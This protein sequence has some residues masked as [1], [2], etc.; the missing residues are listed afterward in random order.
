MEAIVTIEDRERKESREG[1][2]KEKGR[3]G[4]RRVGKRVD[5]EERQREDWIGENM[6]K[7]STSLFLWGETEKEGASV[8]RW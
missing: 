6:E 7:K 3:G 1:K 2:R 4:R 8:I 5:R